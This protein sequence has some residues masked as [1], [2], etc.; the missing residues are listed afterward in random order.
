MVSGGRRGRAWEEAAVAFRFLVLQVGGERCFSLRL[1]IQEGT[2][3]PSLCFGLGNSELP[4]GHPRR[5]GQQAGNWTYRSRPREE[6]QAKDG[7]L[8]DGRAQVFVSFQ[9]LTHL[10]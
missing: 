5:D 2:W 6:K 10:G 7:D 8:G 4:V 9:F 1:E 3:C